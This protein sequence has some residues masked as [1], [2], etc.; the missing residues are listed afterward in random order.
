MSQFTKWREG[1]EGQ[2][3]IITFLKIKTNEHIF[4]GEKNNLNFE[5]LSFMK[6]TFLLKSVPFL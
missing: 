1:A 2:G 4:L 6:N 3:D 5:K